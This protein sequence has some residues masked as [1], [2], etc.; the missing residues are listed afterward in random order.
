MR[1]P[2]PCS[3]ARLRASSACGRERVTPTAWTPWCSAACSSIPPQPQPTSSRRMPGSSAELA[4]DELVLVRLGVLEREGVVVPHRA[5]VGERRPEHH[6]VEVVGHVVVVRDRGRVA[7]PRVPAA[8]Q[9]CL[10]GRG[11]QRLQPRPAHELGRGGDLAWPQPELL[12]VVG[13]LHDVEDVA[14]D[15]EL[16]GDVGATEPELVGRGHDPAEGVGRAHDDGGACIGGPE[17]RPVVGAERHRDVVAEHV[18][19]EIRNAHG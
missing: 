3:A 15:L 5:R 18:G 11:R 12:D 7:P 2:R 8:V 4:A 14:V 16:T 9:P 19:K 10:F 6:L 13:D 1:S 17:R